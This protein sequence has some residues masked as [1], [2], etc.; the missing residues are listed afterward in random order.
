MNMGEYRVHFYF[1]AFAPSALLLTFDAR[2]LLTRDP[3]GKECLAMITNPEIIAINQDPSLNGAWLMQ[4]GHTGREPTTT[5]ITYQILG[6]KLTPKNTYGALLINRSQR[7]MTLRVSWS[8]LI[9]DMHPTPPYAAVRNV[10]QRT[11]LG[12]FKDYWMTVV[13]PHDAVLVTVVALVNGTH[14]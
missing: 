12:I 13:P 3:R 1:W 6:R 14:T 2:K 11:D 8:D 4:Q 9:K 7:V 5:S 10:G